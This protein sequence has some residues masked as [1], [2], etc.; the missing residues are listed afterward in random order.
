MRR[1]FVAESQAKPFQ[2]ELSAK[3]STD[4]PAPG[5][6]LKNKASFTTGAPTAQAAG[7][8]SLNID[9][10]SIRNSEQQE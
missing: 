6:I 2:E 1:K 3:A 10:T 5:G 8:V 9:N 4:K 7:H